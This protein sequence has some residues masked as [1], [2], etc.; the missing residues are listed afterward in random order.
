LLVIALILIVLPV[1]LWISTPAF[2]YSGAFE[3]T[4]A[5]MSI[6]LIPTAIGFGGMFFGLAWMWRIRQ[7]ARKLDEPSWRYRDR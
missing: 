5:G 6:S 3:R 4:I 2:T 1:F 7:A